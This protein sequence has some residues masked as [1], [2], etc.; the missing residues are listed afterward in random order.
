MCLVYKENAL[1]ISLIIILRFWHFTF[2]LLN[3]YNTDFTDGFRTDIC[4][5][6]GLF[7]SLVNPA[8]SSQLTTFSPLFVNSILACVNKSNLSTTK[9]N[10]VLT[11]FF[12]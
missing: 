8:L 4:L 2:K 5:I 10:L 3:I 7:N 11:L 12:A 9:K 1:Y 6:M